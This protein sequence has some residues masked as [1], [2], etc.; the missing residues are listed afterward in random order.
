MKSVNLCSNTI[1]M[2][3][4]GLMV[5]PPKKGRE[6]DAVVEQYYQEKNEIFTGLKTRAKM[7]TEKLNKNPYISCTEVEGAMYAFPTIKI[8]QK[9]ASEM[10]KKGKA[11]DLVYCL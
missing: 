8:P 3:A 4:V 5:N 7:V 11:A 10:N 9:F 2:L 1:G 6:S